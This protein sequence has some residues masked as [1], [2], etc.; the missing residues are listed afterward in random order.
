MIVPSTRSA[1]T[2]V[3]CSFGWVRTEEQ[4]ACKSSGMVSWDTGGKQQLLTPVPTTPHASRLKLAGSKPCSSFPLLPPPTPPKLA[5][6]SS[7]MV[8]TGSV[9]Q[10]HLSS[11]TAG[12]RPGTPIHVK[13]SA[14]RQNTATPRRTA[15]RQWSGMLCLD[16]SRMAAATWGG[17]GVGPGGEHPGGEA[18]GSAAERAATAAGRRQR[19]RWP[20]WC[21][22]ALARAS[23]TRS[24]G[25]FA[26]RAGWAARGC[27]K[28]ASR[29][30]G[31]RWLAS[32]VDGAL[33]LCGKAVNGSGASHCES[34]ALPPL[35]P[36]SV[37]SAASLP[38]I[39]YK[40]A[41]SLTTS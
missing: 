11:S 7:G 20:C 13:P 22:R 39:H 14:D 28:G 16:L 18:A 31:A 36:L 2:W 24:S 23:R 6:P 29:T 1:P 34:P 33:T 5:L 19:R 35:P 15:R 41:R 40:T 17:G 9:R 37:P 8:T 26:G 3:V 30:L 27:R 4:G 32:P 12:S 21:D 38:G 25:P 10:A